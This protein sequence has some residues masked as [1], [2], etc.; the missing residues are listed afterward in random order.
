[1]CLHHSKNWWLAKDFM[2]A[3]M[4]DLYVGYEATARLAELVKDN[5]AIFETK[6]DGRFRAVRMRFETGRQWYQ[7]APDPIKLMV[8]KYY[9]GNVKQVEQGAML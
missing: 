4:G 8:R 6:R 9:N 3:D 2:Q 1:M 5:P 7:T